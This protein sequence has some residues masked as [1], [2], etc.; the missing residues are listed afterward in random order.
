MQN[1]VAPYFLYYVLSVQLVTSTI[2]EASSVIANTILMSYQI[3][4]ASYT[5]PSDMP[6]KM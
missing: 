6:I 1:A 3:A 5:G 2:V 4:G